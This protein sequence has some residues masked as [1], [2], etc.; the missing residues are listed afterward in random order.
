MWD[1]D[2]GQF[3]YAFS[4]G[5]ELTVDEEKKQLVEYL[6]DGATGADYMTYEYDGAGKLTLVADRRVDFPAPR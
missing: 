3:H 6:R 5:G 4:A 1:E 2:D